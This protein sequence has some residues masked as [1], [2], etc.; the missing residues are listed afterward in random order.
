M[1]VRADAYGVLSTYP[2]GMTHLKAPL[3]WS[4]HRES[5]LS[6]G[7]RTGA[8]LEGELGG[9]VLKKHSDCVFQPSR[10]QHVAGAGG[11][12]HL[13]TGQ[14]RPHQ[15]AAPF[16][17][18]VSHQ[19]HEHR[20]LAAGREGGAGLW[21]GSWGGGRGHLSACL[22]G[23]GRQTLQAF[24]GRATGKEMEVWGMLS[25]VSYRIVT[26]LLKRFYD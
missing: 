6:P 2:G 25:F 14:D 11:E 26:C 7:G 5:P 3:V 18:G 23:G 22:G 20:A 15:E 13:E 10:E 17:A 12:G 8:G 21:W 4:V 1:S 16:P 19:G 9:G 24:P